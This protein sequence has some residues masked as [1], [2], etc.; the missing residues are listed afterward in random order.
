QVL[1]AGLSV[2]RVRVKKECGEPVKQPALRRLIVNCCLRSVTPRL[3]GYLFG[4]GNVE[5]QRTGD[6]GASRIKILKA[7]EEICDGVLLFLRTVVAV[8]H[9]R[10]THLVKSREIL[11][12][13][14]NVVSEVALG[15]NFLDRETVSE[16]DAIG[17]EFFKY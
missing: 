5:N 8:G 7:Y 2:N 11:G 9:E 16:N 10:C 4:G 14:P 15:A 13:I 17:R 12:C 1:P 6:L 3:V